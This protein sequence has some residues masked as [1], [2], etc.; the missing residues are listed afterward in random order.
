MYR[1]KH[2]PFKALPSG[3]STAPMVFTIVIKEVKLMALQRGIRIHQYLDYWLVRARSHQT[4]LQHTQTLVHVSICQDP[5]W[6]VNLEK[7]ELDPKQ[8][9]DII[10]YQ[11]DLK[12]GKVK[13]TLDRWQTF[14]GKT[15]ELLAGPPI[16]SGS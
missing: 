3:L 10:G 8:V 16:R 7:L 11:F 12:E 2:I 14:T 5:G 6:L 13:H 1:G 9:F 4:Y 15:Q